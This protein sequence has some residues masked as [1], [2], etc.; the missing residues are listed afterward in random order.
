[1]TTR[2]DAIAAMRRA[3]ARAPIVR[4]LVAQL[5]A[6]DFR[7]ASN[8]ILVGVQ[9]IMDQTLVLCW[10]LNELGLPYERMTMCGKAYSL[11]PQVVEELRAL[12]IHVPPSRDYDLMSSQALDLVDDLRSLVPVIAELR[13]STVSPRMLILDDGGQALTHLPAM[14]DPPFVGAGVEQTASGFWQTGIL[15]VS[16]PVVDVGSSAVKRI[17]EPPI[18][19]DAVLRRAQ[20]RLDAYRA[21]PRVG[22]VGLG[23]IGL[24]MAERLLEGHYELSVYDT[25]PDGYHRVRRHLAGSIRDVI[26][27]S[28]VIFGCTGSDIT[29]DLDEDLLERPL[30]FRAREFISLSSADDEFYTLKSMLRL[31]GKAPATYRVESIPDL[32][33]EVWGVPIALPRNGFPINFDNTRESAPLRDIQGTLAALIGGLCQAAGL[34]NSRA[35][36]QRI[37][38]DEGL[39]GWLMR[40]WRKVLEPRLTLK[41]GGKPLA[42]RPHQSVIFK[43]SNLRTEP[44]SVPLPPTFGRWTMN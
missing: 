30:T 34:M 33:G 4:D 14:L 21:L 13:D 22:V 32:S 28:D 7:F 17:C 36:S 3:V 16:L 15:S 38:L 18:I 8:V 43:I 25:R 39:Q 12:G 35:L 29:R 6:Q 41:S 20:Q 19:I 24:A 10:A 27:R 42:D 5:K 40:R 31:R 11:C 9:H 26:E 23:F 2:D 1:M 37:V 44:R